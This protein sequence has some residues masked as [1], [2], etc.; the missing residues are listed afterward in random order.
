MQITQAE[1]FG[2]KP[3]S[4]YCSKNKTIDIKPIVNGESK[5]IIDRVDF[6]QLVT[7]TH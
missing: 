6:I 4:F 2:L 3:D 7:I 5:V 1:K